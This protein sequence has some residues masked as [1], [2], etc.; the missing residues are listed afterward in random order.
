M[1]FVLK[2]PRKCNLVKDKVKFLGYEVSAKGVNRSED[3]IKAVKEINIPKTLKQL[4]N[5]LGLVAYQHKFLK[6]ISEYTQILGRAIK[7]A[8]EQ[9]KERW[10]DKI[11]KKNKDIGIE[12]KSD[13]IDAF[14]KIKNLVAEDITLAFPDDSEESEPL[15]LWTDSS[16]TTMGSCLTQVQ[17]E[18]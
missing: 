10:K 3:H 9:I 6:N 18:V 14:N 17:K 7:R 16:N 2:Y 12:L 5:F 13:E 11:R 1:S 4:Q 15:V 8:N